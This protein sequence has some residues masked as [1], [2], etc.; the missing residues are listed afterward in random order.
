MPAN[1]LV[2]PISVNWRAVHA[3]QLQPAGQASTLPMRWRHPRQLRLKG[4]VIEQQAQRS[5]LCKL[6][7]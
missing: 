5:L 2:G 6:I 7:S 4:A 3:P 1:A